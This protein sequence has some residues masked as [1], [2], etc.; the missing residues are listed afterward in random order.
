VQND[1]SGIGWLLV[2]VTLDST[3]GLPPTDPM[4]WDRIQEYLPQLETVDLRCIAFFAEFHEMFTLVA[5]DNHTRGISSGK[6]F[7]FTV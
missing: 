1:V 4:R 3:Q 7:E 5:L 2:R 6:L